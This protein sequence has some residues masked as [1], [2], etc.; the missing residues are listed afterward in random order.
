MDE[1]YFLHTISMQPIYLVYTYHFPNDHDCATTKKS[2]T[3]EEYMGED[4]H[5]G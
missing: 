4:Q 3:K 5:R 1:D 2:W